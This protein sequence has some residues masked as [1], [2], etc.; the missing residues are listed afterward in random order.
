MSAELSSREQLHEVLAAFEHGML[1]TRTGDGALRARPMAV[2]EI[3]ADDTIWFTTSDQSGKIDE[4]A[5]DAHVCITFQEGHRFVSLSGEAFL[6]HDREKQ[7]QL[8]R[9]AWRPWFPGGEDDPH[10]V[11]LRVVPSEGEYWDRGGMQGLKY[12]FEAV[13]A[14]VERRPMQTDER[15]HGRVEL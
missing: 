9:E 10:L 1:V 8:W 7:R 11:L 13:R 2:A 6:V 12:L 15:E 14:R 5:A 4:I 3:G